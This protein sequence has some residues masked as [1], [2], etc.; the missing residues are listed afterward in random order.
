MQR[1]EPHR[2]PHGR[3]WTPFPQLA[4]YTQSGATTN[5]T[6]AGADNA[7]RLTRDAATFTHAAVGIT[8][9]SVVGN[10]H[11]F[12]SATLGHIG[13]IPLGGVP[14]QQRGRTRNR[15]GC[16]LPCAS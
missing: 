11:R 9:Q 4:A 6:Y 3:Y 5:Q 7:Q 12:S 14:H 13:E 8:G 16:D 2:H 1:R 15:G 10:G